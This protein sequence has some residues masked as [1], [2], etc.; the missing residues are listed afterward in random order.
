MTY[1][2]RTQKW[3]PVRNL[4]VWVAMVTS[5]SQL[6]KVT[7]IIGSSQVD[8]LINTEESVTI[9][10][11]N[12][13]Q[14][15][16]L[17]PTSARLLSATGIN[18]PCQCKTS[19]DIYIPSLWCLFTRAVV[20]ADTL[21]P[22]LGAD[23]LIY[24][25]LILGCITGKFHENKTEHYTQSTQVIGT[26]QQITV[27]CS[28]LR[29]PIQSLLNKHPTLLMP[30]REKLNA[31]TTRIR[32]TIDTSN[33]KPTSAKAHQLLEEKDKFAKQEFTALINTG[34][35]RPSRS[36]WVS[37]LY[38]LPKSTPSPVSWGYRIHRMHLCKGVSPCQW[39]LLGMTNY[40]HIQG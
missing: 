10:S 1:S 32:Y 36:P 21:S 26:T 12:F 5:N 8:I 7:T 35:I 13:A 19:F 2:T 23:F 33:S 18:I 14:G 17:N 20:V 29:K 24:Y 39:D 31:S 38:L 34:I 40:N 6:F 15:L 25:S 27:N 3:T 30:Y 16:H 4:L 22:L 11:T 28:Q 37:P 9:L